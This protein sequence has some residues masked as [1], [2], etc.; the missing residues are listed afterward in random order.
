M[1]IRRIF[2]EIL[3][4]KLKKNRFISFFICY[5]QNVHD[6]LWGQD[7]R[8]LLYTFLTNFQANKFAVVPF[9]GRK[10]YLSHCQSKAKKINENFEFI[11]IY[12][13]NSDEN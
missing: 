4:K 8:L 9:T 10:F 13:V 5:K 1:A 2:S 6:L 11:A 3:A 7:L 12:R